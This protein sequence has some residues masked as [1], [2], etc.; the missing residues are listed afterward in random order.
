VAKKL[1]DC[2]KPG[3]RLW[4]KVKNRSYWL[5]ALTALRP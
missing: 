1:T 4:V 2:Y 3:E 5:E